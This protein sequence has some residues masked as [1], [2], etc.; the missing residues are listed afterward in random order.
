MMVD[1]NG[2]Q[3]WAA[4]CNREGRERAAR[5]GADSG[6]VMMATAA[7]DGGGRQQWQMQTMTAAGNNGT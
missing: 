4:D 1:N 6:V 2:T 3:D 5:E 7:E